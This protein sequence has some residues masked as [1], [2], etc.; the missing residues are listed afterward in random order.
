MVDVSR[1]TS[2]KKIWF[3][4]SGIVV[5]VAIL[6]F[7]LEKTHVINLIGETSPST[8]TTGPTKEQQ[9]QAAKTAN[10]SKQAF[11]DDAYTSD[12]EQNPSAEPSLPSINILA[13]QSGSSITVISKIYHVAE[14]TC[15]LRVTNGISQTEQ[16]AQVIYQP[17]FSSCAGF[18][19]PV[20][21]LGTG[22]WNISITFTPTSGQPITDST[23]LEVE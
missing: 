14:G 20:T 11:L 3:V 4:A 10:D 5:L 12:S 18:S 15:M 7:T 21:E 22:R 9:A 1:N 6:L 23:S 13:T 2:K 8:N 17:E 19:I 16:S